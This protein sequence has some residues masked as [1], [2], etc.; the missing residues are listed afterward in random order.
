MATHAR[1]SF[2]WMRQIHTEENWW[3][4]IAQRIL[5]S[6]MEIKM[7]MKFILYQ[8]LM[9]LHAPYMHLDCLNP[10]QL[11]QVSIRAFKDEIQMFCLWMVV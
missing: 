1:Q 8:Y 9:E 3:F 6:L 2:A 5:T 11:T 4:I 7:M 10:L